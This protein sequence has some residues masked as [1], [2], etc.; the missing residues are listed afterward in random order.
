MKFSQIL[1]VV[2]LSI[3]PF[4]SWSYTKNY[5]VAAIGFYNLENL[6]DTLDDPYKFDE[7]FLPNGKYNYTSKIYESKLHNLAKVISGIAA[8]KE[9]KYQIPGGVAILGISE[10]ENINVVKD[11][12][13]QPALKSR[14]YRIVHFESPDARGIDVGMIYRPDLFR[15]LSAQSLYVDISADNSKSKTRDILHTCGILADDTIHVLVGHWPSRSGGEAASMWKR[16]KAA[17]VCKRI[18]DSLTNIN[19]DTKILIMGDL[20]DD[21]ISPSVA[22]TLG[23]KGGDVK[24]IKTSEL[25]NPWL[26]FYKKGIGTLGYDDRWNLFDQIIISGGWIHNTNKKWKYNKAEIHS[27]Q[28]MVSQFGRFKGYPHRSFSNGIWIDGYSD[29]FP[30]LLYFIKEIK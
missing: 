9:S 6:F 15:V 14:N 29:H 25:Y 30:T 28:F 4:I 2:Y 21:P 7:D 27:R 10:I 16:Q 11:L 24:N 23:A 13:N 3:L 17:S 8:D 26:S 5:Q 18:V 19:P 20:N 12:I 22:K 1:A